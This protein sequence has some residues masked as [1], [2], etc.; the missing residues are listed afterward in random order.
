[1]M[2]MIIIIIVILILILVSM[3]NI[4]NFEHF[5]ELKYANDNDQYDFPFK[6]PNLIC[7]EHANMIIERVL[8]DLKDS[9]VISGKYTDVRN[10]K[11]TWIPKN[12][13]LVKPIFE[14]LSK[15][16][17]IPFENAEDL[18]VVRYQPN[19]YYK[20]HHDACCDDVK[21]CHEFVKRGGQRKM[22]ILIYLNDGFEGGETSFKNL[23]MKVKGEIG[24]AIIFYPLE[25][26]SNK[27]HP[28]ALHA[29]T[30]VI[31]GE[32][33]IANVWFREKEFR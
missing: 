12:D 2:I 28:L 1:M 24:D 15:T 5:E 32:K 21:E 6:I 23:N 9:E 33:W 29:G 31:K 16:F 8:N 18:Q 13:P 11:H 17:N 3:F 10:S 26:N 4:N 27:C 22:T 30:P 14:L 19:Q 7:K 25:K 20:D